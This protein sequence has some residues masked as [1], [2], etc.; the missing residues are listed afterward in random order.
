[1]FSTTLPACTQL[2]IT[3]LA[4]CAAQPDCNVTVRAV[5]ALAED[6]GGASTGTIVGIAAGVGAWHGLVMVGRSCGPRRRGPRPG[7][8]VL[9][10]LDPSETRLQVEDDD[11]APVLPSDMPPAQAQRQVARSRGYRG[12]EPDAPHHRRPTATRVVALTAT[13]WNSCGLAAAAKVVELARLADVV[14]VPESFGAQT[15]VLEGLRL[16]V[17][18]GR[19][20]NGARGGVALVSRHQ[21]DGRQPA[22]PLG[23]EVCCDVLPKF[24]EQFAAQCVHAA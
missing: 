20:A 1:M 7:S 22:R 2:C 6:T 18:H 13:V 16:S 4:A 24:G 11:D 10:I 23:A 12:H 9:T 3:I 21:L 14:I 5:A 19:R 8:V 17:V 15:T